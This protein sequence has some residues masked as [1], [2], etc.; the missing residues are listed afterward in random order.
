M[1]GLTLLLCASCARIQPPPGGPPDAE[2]P[3]ARVLEPN[4][5]TLHLAGRQHFILRFDEYMDRAS[6]RASLSLNPRPEGELRLRW[7]GRRLSVRP[8]VDL[9]ADR[10]YTL[11]LGTGARDLAGNH[12]AAPLR[13]PFA[14]GARLDTLSLDLWVQDRRSEGNCEVWLWPLDGTPARRFGLAPW[15]SSPDEGGHVLFQGLPEGEW[16]ALAVEDQDHNGWW[17][18]GL[19]RAGLPSRRLCAPDTARGLPALLRLETGL[20]VDSLSLEGGQFLDRERVQFSGRLEPPALAAWP[21]SLRRGPAADSLRLSLLDLV[22]T[23]G[24]RPA[25]AGLA[26]G[27][28]GW[29]LLLAEEA[30]SLPHVLSFRDGRDSLR[31]RPPPG[32]FTAPLVDVASLAQAWSGGVLRVEATHAV[33][34]RADLARQVAGADTLATVLER[35]GACAVTLRP[36]RP[37]GALLLQKGLLCAGARCW[38][39]TLLTLAVPA[40]PLATATGGLQWRWDRSP[41]ERGWL[42]VV[43]RGELSRAVPLAYAGS[44]EDLPAGPATFSLY[45]DRDGSLAWSPGRLPADGRA[46]EPAEPFLALP[47]TVEILPGWIQG[48]VLFH[49]PEWIP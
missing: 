23:A 42:L 48:D 36:A 4:P 8:A 17:D 14:T 7:H 25:M 5:G 21:D 13:L 49:L 40:A 35:L 6:V 38:P 19:E 41:R 11:E 27:E 22:D 39:D 31:L 30:D 28:G 16:L 37:G 29:R 33:T 44:L 12:L 18:P 2:A 26:P 1:V 10:T 20:F 47:D 15:R 32:P 24:R 34:A 3:R 45:Q 9:P 43:R 46:W